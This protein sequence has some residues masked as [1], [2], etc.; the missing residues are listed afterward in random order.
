MEVISLKFDDLSFRDESS[1]EFLIPKYY[2]IFI[3]S[4]DNVI[5]RIVPIIFLLNIDSASQEVDMW[6][7]ENLGE[8]GLTYT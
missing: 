1:L 6:S 4:S 2:Q 5:H 8:V 3:D 7:D